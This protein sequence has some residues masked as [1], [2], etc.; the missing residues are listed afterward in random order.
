MQ[1]RLWPSAQG[2]Q[3]HQRISLLGKRVPAAWCSLKTEQRKVKKP[4]RATFQVAL[5]MH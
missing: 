4:V 3:P 2:G 1:H 5:S